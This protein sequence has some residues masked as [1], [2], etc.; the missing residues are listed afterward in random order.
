MS[1]LMK[2]VATLCRLCL[3][4]RLHMSTSTGES[5]VMLQL[6]MSLLDQFH[7][8][9]SIDINKCISLTSPNNLVPVSPDGFQ[10]MYWNRL[11]SSL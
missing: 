5:S 8:R 9:V 11:C 4:Q 10:G 2:L 3:L 1:E 6:M 7:H